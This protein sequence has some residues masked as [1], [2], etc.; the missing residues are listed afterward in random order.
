MAKE[1]RCM[2]C[3]GRLASTGRCV[4]CGWDSTKNDTH[5]R[6]NTHNETTTHLHQGEC[7]EN[8][9]RDNDGSPVRLNFNRR[10]SAGGSSSWSSSTTAGGSQSRS[11]SSGGSQKRSN[12][13]AAGGSQKQSGSSG[14]SGTGSQA[15]GG[16]KSSGWASKNLNREKRKAQAVKTRVTRKQ[17]ERSKETTRQFSSANPEKASSAKN[18]GKRSAGAGKKLWWLIFALIAITVILDVG[19]FLMDDVF[20]ELLETV[21]DTFEEI[22]IGGFGED[23]D[24]EAS[25]AVCP[26]RQQWDETAEGYLTTELSQGNYYVGY[27]I[28]AGTYQLECLDGIAYVTWDAL[29]EASG[30][31]GFVI[32]YSE[33]E[34]ADY[35]ESWDGE[36]CPWFELSE[37]FEL[38]ENMV[39]EIEGVGSGLWLTGEEDETDSLME[40]ESQS[41][42]EQIFFSEDRTWV[43]GEDFEPGVYDICAAGADAYVWVDIEKEDGSSDGFS[44]SLYEGID[45]FLRYSLEEGDEI[46]VTTYGEDVEVTLTPS[47]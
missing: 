12:S 10:K 32:L 29:D 16:R 1:N 30:T 40:H 11:G 45:E 44:L 27:D 43:V 37:V 47:W 31:H 20:P 38:S 26:E 13:T 23:D 3:G 14:G 2:L 18:G 35:T 36:E 4:V 22:G 6:L 17:E 19:E 42:S 39:L 8:L 46:S 21:S 15:P 9:N 7:E 25:D 33:E 28:P 5:Y 41:A 34:R 24:G